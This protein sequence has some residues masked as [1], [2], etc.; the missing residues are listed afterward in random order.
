M[1]AKAAAEDAAV[2]ASP[3]AAAVEAIAVAIVA[4]KNISHSL[5]ILFLY[6]FHQM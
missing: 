3:V 6:F 2:A 5:V 4:A 1:V